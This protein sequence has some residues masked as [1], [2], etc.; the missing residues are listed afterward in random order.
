MAKKTDI[1]GIIKNFINEVKKSIRINYMYLFGSYAKGKDNINS[2][3]DIAIISNDFTGF[4]FEDRKKINPIV[5]KIN[6]NLEVHPFTLDEYKSNNP[7]LD[8]I[9]ST[10]KK[11]Y[12]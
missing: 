4:K 5:L 9:I 7:F 6:T 10:G 12:P 3:I 8:E 11:V 2:D 1:D